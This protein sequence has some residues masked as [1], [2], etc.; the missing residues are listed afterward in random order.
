[1]GIRRFFKKSKIRHQL[2]GSS[3]RY[4]H[5]APPFAGR[6]VRL[7]LLLFFLAIGGCGDRQAS[8]EIL[9]EF[10]QQPGETYVYRIADDVEWEIENAGEPGS[11]F[12]HQ[13]EQK[14]QQFSHY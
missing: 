2:K 13:Q 10:K 7:A 5:K 6:F 1:M 3:D 12:Y 14:S 4:V 11:A 9:L 8:K